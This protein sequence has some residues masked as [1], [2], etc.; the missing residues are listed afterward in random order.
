MN[1]GFRIVPIDYPEAANGR[2]VEYCRSTLAR[3]TGR[4][5]EFSRTI[6]TYRNE[7]DRKI[8]TLDKDKRKLKQSMVD[9]SKRMQE[10]RDERC[11]RLR[12]DVGMREN[13]LPKFIS[14]PKTADDRVKEFLSNLKISNHVNE[15]L[16]STAHYGVI[17]LA[18]VKGKT[19]D[20]GAEGS[21][22]PISNAASR[23]PRLTAMSPVSDDGAHSIDSVS[24][25]GSEKYRA[26]FSRK[27]SDSIFT[28]EKM[29][30]GTN[31][32]VSYRGTK[33][34]FAAMRGKS[35]KVFEG[36]TNNK[37]VS[38][39]SETQPENEQFESAAAAAHVNE[40]DDNVPNLNEQTTRSSRVRRLGR[41]EADASSKDLIQHDIIQEDDQ[42]DTQTRIRRISIAAGNQSRRRSVAKR[43][44]D[45][46]KDRKIPGSSQTGTGERNTSQFLPH[47]K[48]VM[49][50]ASAPSSY[51][52]L[53]KLRHCGTRKLLRAFDSML[54]QPKRR[55]KLRNGTRR[56][57]FLP[58]LKGAPKVTILGDSNKSEEQDTLGRLPDIDK[59]AKTIAGSRERKTNW[60]NS[61]SSVRLCKEMTTS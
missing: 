2:R 29:S 55:R 24:S 41:M 57:H 19:R 1:K 58:D 26:K 37:K 20:H 49:K 17:R 8:H 48:D 13:D 25:E 31:R 27:M 22:P 28:I 16:N 51:L 52:D 18:D 59:L 10:I 11:R 4:E 45:V 44:S 42:P 21:L 47:T 35:V 43:V 56:R 7:M 32:L 50:E 39:V 40:S 5:V 54:S 23:F 38:N 46:S 30:D 61:V 60:Q 33:P 36:K 6:N 3:L 15:R 34:Y 9:Y 14:E 12:G 53:L